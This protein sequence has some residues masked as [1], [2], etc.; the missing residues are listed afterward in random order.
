MN[1]FIQINELEKLEKSANRKYAM[2]SKSISYANDQRKPSE[3]NARY[4]G[5]RSPY[6]HAA[7][8]IKNNNNNIH[9]NRR[10]SGLFFCWKSVEYVFVCAR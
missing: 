1:H 5:F 9:S 6:N 4:I 2:P 7:E 3:M 8:I 10:N